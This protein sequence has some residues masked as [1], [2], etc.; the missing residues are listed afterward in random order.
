M[1]LA[2]G[3]KSFFL[4]VCIVDAGLNNMT[5]MCNNTLDRKEAWIPWIVWGYTLRMIIPRIEHRT[6]KNTMR[7]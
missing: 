5:T 1:G 6:N 4:V 7:M 3:I 2:V